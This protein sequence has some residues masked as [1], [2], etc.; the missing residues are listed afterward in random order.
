LSKEALLS[1]S[2]VL[3]VHTRRDHDNLQPIAVDECEGVIVVQLEL[4]GLMIR[5]EDP[6]VPVNAVVRADLVDLMARILVAVFQAEGGRFDDRAS[7]H[8]LGSQGD[9]LFAAIERQ[10]STTEPGESAT[11][12]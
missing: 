12:V 1:L 6:A 3:A 5:E 11:P 9:R 7:L 4:M 8:S 2:T 10:A